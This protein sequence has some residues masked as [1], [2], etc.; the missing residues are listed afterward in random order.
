[1]HNWIEWLFVNLQQSR[2]DALYPFYC[3]MILV[4]SNDLYNELT[5]L[6]TLDTNWILSNSLQMHN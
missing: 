3:N 5:P 4:F 6:K 1:M 2:I